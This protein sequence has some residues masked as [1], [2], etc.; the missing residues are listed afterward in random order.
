PDLSDGGDEG[1]LIILDGKDV[2][3]AFAA[4]LA[5]ADIDDGRAEAR[6]LDDA[7][8]AVSDQKGRVAQ[9]A[10]EEGS[11]HVAPGDKTPVAGALVPAAHDTGVAGV[12]VG[13]DDD[14]ALD[15]RGDGRLEQAR[16]RRVLRGV[17]VSGRMKDEQGEAPGLD[18]ELA[19]D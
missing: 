10:E 18:V 6:G 17:V 13:M 12:V 2:V 8:G 9:Q 16:R 14:D 11:R 3:A 7:A 5:R 15:A 19:R 1:G 4:E